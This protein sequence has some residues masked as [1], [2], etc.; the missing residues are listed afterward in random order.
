[1]T[2]KK[3]IAQA[4]SDA[5]VPSACSSGYV[6]PGC[7]QALY[8][9]PTTKATQ[10]SN[11]LGVTGYVG[12]YA[13]NADLQVGPVVPHFA[14]HLISHVICSSSWSTSVLISR[15][16]P[17]LCR[18]LMAAAIRKIRVRLVSKLISTLSTP[19]VSRLGSPLPLSLSARST[20]IRLAVC[21]TRSISCSGR[22]HPPKS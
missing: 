9:I 17:S 18:R 20:R 15:A 19:S 2:P 6:T 5:A 4:P 22:A 1:M 3:P 13:N 12:Q 14:F 7:L 16:R 11:T 21:W 10:K 8:G